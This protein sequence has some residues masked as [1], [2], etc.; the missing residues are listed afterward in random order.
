MLIE[1]K[2]IDLRRSVDKDVY[3]VI[4]HFVVPQDLE[5]LTLTIEEPDFPI[6]VL[7]L[8]DSQ[9]ILRAEGRNIEHSLQIRIAEAEHQTSLGARWGLIPA[10]EWIMAMEVPIEVQPETWTCNYTIEGNRLYAR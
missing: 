6:S 4:E 2:Q 5:E 8:Y 1:H 10:G 3:F 7:L 9:H